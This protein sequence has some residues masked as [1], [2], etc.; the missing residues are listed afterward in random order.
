MRGALLS[1]KGRDGLTSLECLLELDLEILHLRDIFNSNV[2]RMKIIENYFL[3]KK[4]D[5]IFFII[6]LLFNKLQKLLKVI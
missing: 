6:N 2:C 5:I 4:F 1:I 3:F